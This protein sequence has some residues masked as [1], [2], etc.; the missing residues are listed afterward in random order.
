PIS[1]RSC[2]DPVRSVLRWGGVLVA[3][4]LVSGCSAALWATRRTAREP[5][6]RARLYVPRLF[7]PL[8]PGSA[9]PNRR[10]PRAASGRPGVL[11]VVPRAL[12]SRA[13]APLAARG[14]VVLRLEESD[15]VD[16]GVACDWLRRQ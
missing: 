2:S 14:L 5:A 16:V 4:L 7:E 3:V 15:G 11:V 10:V 6:F 13:A 12:F 9:Y 8:L 1:G